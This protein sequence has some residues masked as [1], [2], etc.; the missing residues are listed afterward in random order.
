[1]ANIPVYLKRRSVDGTAPTT[2][3]L[4]DGETAVN[5]VTKT[6]Y[7]RI[8]GSIIAIANYFNGAF[9]DL[10]GK[11]TTVSGYGIT[12]AV[13]TSTN[14]SIGGLKT[15]TGTGGIV[16]FNAAGAQVIVA[17]ASGVD[18]KINFRAGAAL[19]KTRWELTKNTTAESGS[20]AGSDM[21]LNAFDDSGTFLA[22][23]FRAIRSTQV[24]DFTNKPTVGGTNVALES[25]SISTTAPLTG[26]GSLTADRTFGISAATTSDPGTM[27]AADKTKLDNVASGTWTPTAANV[28]N[29]TSIT[30]GTFH[31][32]RVGNQVSFSGYV[33]YTPS[34]ANTSTQISLTLPIAS[35]LGDTLADAAG[36]ATASITAG[37][38]GF[39]RS[40]GAGKLLLQTQTSNKTQITY[41]LSGHY[42]IN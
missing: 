3:N 15:F 20:N 31:Y 38:I 28:A 30:A 35:T 14:Q 11:P 5:T 9:A 23:I 40:D 34:A 29:A 16:S 18:A 27:S 32:I 24:L 6:I 42:T 22:R 25:R 19:N 1:M 21:D 7:T 41:R 33:I 4:A 12:D 26:G 10:S 17:S 37:T 8:G 39:V 36:T 13:D 2:A